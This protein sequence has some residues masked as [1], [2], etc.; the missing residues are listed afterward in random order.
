MVCGYQL[1]LTR[2]FRKMLP[3]Q[4]LAL[5]PAATGTARGTRGSWVGTEGRWL[6]PAGRGTSAEGGSVDPGYWGA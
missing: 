1:P 3:N 5:V 6:Q 4:G 2:V